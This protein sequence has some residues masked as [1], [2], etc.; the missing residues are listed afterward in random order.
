MWTL[1]FLFLTILN[2]LQFIY[3]FLVEVDIRINILKLKGVFI[4]KFFNKLKIKLKFRIKHGYIYIYFKK[5]EKKL[6]ISQN[7]VSFVFII[8]LF[9]EFYFREQL[10]SMSLSSSF[11]YNL[12]SCITATTS[13]YLDIIQKGILAKIKN[14]KKSAHIFTKIDPKYNEDIFNLRFNQI[15]RVSVVDIIYTLLVTLIKTWSG[16]EKRKRKFRKA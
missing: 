10:L 13:G 11:G 12:D 3:P 16:N 5:K 8:N 2:I 7:N 14:N 15:I 9:R 6:K 1:I 4:I